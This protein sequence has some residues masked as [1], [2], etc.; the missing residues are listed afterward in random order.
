MHV[1]NRNHGRRL[2]SVLVASLLLIIAGC[3]SA[4]QE[5]QPDQE[6]LDRR[7]DAINEL[8]RQTR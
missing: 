2:G 6:M 8:D 7:D 5:R 3:A 4:P 1:K